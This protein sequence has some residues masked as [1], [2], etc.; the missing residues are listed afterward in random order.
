MKL[1]IEIR[2]IRER[3][4][5]SN[6]RRNFLERCIP[7][8]GIGA[9]IGVFKGQFSPI[10]LSVT[11]PNRLHLVDPWYLLGVEWSWARGNRSTIDALCSILRRFRQD[12][13]SGR[14]VLNIGDD[15]DVLRTFPNGYFD[16]VYLDTTH[17]YEQTTKELELLKDVVKSGGIIAGDDWVE[18]P[19]HRHHGDVR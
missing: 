8:R 14:V 15:L 19:S 3:F 17:D 10:L 18:R 9:E 1:P 4:G 16:W 11:Q 12:L 13:S 2:P 6:E 5:L 7:K